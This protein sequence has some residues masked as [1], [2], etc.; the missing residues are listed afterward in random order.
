MVTRACKTCRRLVKGN[1][2]P[3][4]KT[5]ELTRNWKGIL[6]V[7]DPVNSEVAKEAGI[8]SPGKFAIRVK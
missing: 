3:I 1:M 6:V 8:T 4:C 5:S 2:C 7:M